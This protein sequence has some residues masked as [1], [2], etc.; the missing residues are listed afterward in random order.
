M[1]WLRANV[2]FPRPP[3]CAFVAKLWKFASAVITQ[4]ARPE[5]QPTEMAGGVQWKGTLFSLIRTAKLITLASTGAS[6]PNPWVSVVM[7]I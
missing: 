5:R 2:S 1:R 4:E 7:G 6:P 3:I